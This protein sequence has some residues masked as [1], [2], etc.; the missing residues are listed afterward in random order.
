LQSAMSY[1]REKDFAGA[2]KAY[3]ELADL[4]DKHAYADVEA[5]CHRALAAIADDR[6]AGLKHLADA[7]AA[8]SH[9]HHLS[10]TL[11][12]QT[13]A[14]I[15][16][17]RVLIAAAAGENDLSAASLKQLEKMAQNS[18]DLIVQRSYHAANGAMLL[19]GGKYAEAA[20]ELAE[21]AENALSAVRLATAY[22]KSG[23]ADDA[24]KVRQRL[25]NTHRTLLEDALVKL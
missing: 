2:E 15:L 8:L 17:A 25:A 5:E 19:G 3:T 16:R 18:R 21:D 24:A 10:Q 13:M 9:P 22:E 1:I 11:R 20:S 7:E 12:D 23:N 4:A 14:K 6:K